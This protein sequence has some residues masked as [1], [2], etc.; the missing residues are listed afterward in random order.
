MSLS[1]DALYMREITELVEVCEEGPKTG[2]FA[3][4]SGRSWHALRGRLSSNGALNGPIFGV[5]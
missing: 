3:P 5:G 1:L 2:P 4:K